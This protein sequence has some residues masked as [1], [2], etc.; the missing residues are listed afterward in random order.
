MFGIEKAQARDMYLILRV[1]KL[2]SMR[3]LSLTQKLDQSLEMILDG[4]KAEN[5][6]I[7]LAM[8]DDTPM[9][10]I[11]AATNRKIIGKQQVIT[12][13]SISGRTFLKNEPILIKNINEHPDFAPKSRPGKYKT[14]SLMCV[15][16]DTAGG[17]K[18]FGV[19]NAS[20]HREDTSFVQADL[21]LLMDYASWISPILQSSFLMENLALEKE[22][23]KQISYEL[24]IKQKELM[25]ST[26]E[27]SELVQMVV[28]DFKSPLSAII[29][30]LEL[31][32]YIGMSEDQKP[33]VGTALEGS[34]NLL[35]MINDFLQLARLD[36]W[37]ENLQL[38]NTS[39]MD[40]VGKEV[41]EVRPV[42]TSKNISLE[43][44]AGS[45]IR[46]STHENML[47]H[48]VKNLLSNAVKYTQ[49]NGSVK[50]FW[51]LKEARRL[52]DK[53]NKIIEFCV[54]DSGP[55]V[56]D[57]MKKTIF[58][59][60]SRITSN[61]HIQGTGVGLY[62]CNRIANMMGGKIWVEDAVPHGSRFCVTMF[63][64]EDDCD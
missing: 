14:D 49:D 13:D 16:L 47:H 34:Q 15:P 17:E 39:I 51:T 10:K 56:P 4:I 46:F 28:H 43:V 32:S 25:I 60:F 30:N 29:S 3:N 63:A 1:I 42:A 50:I 7:M 45:D 38:K 59:K 33:L 35:E 9:M 27:R 40:V 31:L 55:G 64:P 19:I 11:W 24:E 8:E 23:Y 37:Q 6:S 12:N 54:E 44:M 18:A 41:E 36:Q 52:T 48:L 62:I 53:C 57:G 5:G 20:D 2:L 61:S 21:S 26:A 58:D 22:K